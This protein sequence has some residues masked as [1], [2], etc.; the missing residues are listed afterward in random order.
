MKIEN[1]KQVM[2]YVKTATC[3]PEFLLEALKIREYASFRANLAYFA[4]LYF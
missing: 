4:R 1:T 3:H 2:V